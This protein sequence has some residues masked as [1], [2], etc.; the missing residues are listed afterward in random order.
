MLSGVGE[1]ESEARVYS[2]R[3][4]FLP[5]DSGRLIIGVAPEPCVTPDVDLRLTGEKLLR[6]QISC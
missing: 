4:S 6:E 1:A 2:C 3:S 5:Y